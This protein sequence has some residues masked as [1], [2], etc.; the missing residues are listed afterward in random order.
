M[1]LF[2]AFRA[3]NPSNELSVISSGDGFSWTTRKSYPN[4]QIGSAPA[5]AVFG[6][7]L[8][9]AFQANDSSHTLFVTSSTDG[10]NF[11][12]AQA[13]PNIQIGSAPIMYFQD[14]HDPIVENDPPIEA[15]LYIAFQA[16]DSSHRL[17]VT[18]AA[19]GAGFPTAEPYPDIHIGST[20]AV[21]V[22]PA[23][24]PTMAFQADDPSNR[25][26]FTYSA[27]ENFVVWLSPAREVPGIQIGSAPALA[28]FGGK[29][30]IAFEANDPS[31]RL[32]T[33][34]MTG[35]ED[36]VSPANPIPGVEIGSAPAMASFR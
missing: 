14:A 27:N 24:Y 31:H 28:N 21:D 26:F 30:F 19:T 4:I 32:F 17:F 9:I 18:S 36:W 12:T 29:L 23:S 13:Y 6:G 33:A 20:P 16:N 34:Y 8:Y 25:L 5:M 11:P 2:I 15:I 35:F 7:K 10:V 3:N 22:S 1:P